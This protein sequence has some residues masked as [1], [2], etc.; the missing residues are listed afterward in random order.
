MPLDAYGGGLTTASCQILG[1][2]KLVEDAGEATLEALEK[3]LYS[4]GEQRLRDAVVN[5]SQ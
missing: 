5:R 1:K 3:R 2:W 4:G